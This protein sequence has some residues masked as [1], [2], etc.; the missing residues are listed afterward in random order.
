MTARSPLTRFLISCILLAASSALALAQE[1]EEWT[2]TYHPDVTREQLAGR[3]EQVKARLAGTFIRLLPDNSFTAHLPGR[4]LAG[5]VVVGGTDAQGS[6]LLTLVPVQKP[7]QP[8]QSPIAVT[9]K[10]G[11]LTMRNAM[12]T[13]RFV[14]EAG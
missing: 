8:T 12:I 10:E 6:L 7:R 11:S 4:D 3:F 2:G 13:I 9:Y 5:T 14:K 1:N